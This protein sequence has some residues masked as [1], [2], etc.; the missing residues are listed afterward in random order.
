MIHS[1]T[2]NPSFSVCPANILILYSQCM[3]LIVLVIILS[4]ENNR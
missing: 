1:K 3:F 2:L 4:D